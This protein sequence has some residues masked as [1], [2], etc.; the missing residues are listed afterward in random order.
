[1]IHATTEHARRRRLP[2]HF[3]SLE[4]PIGLRGLVAAAPQ[5]HSLMSS[6]RSRGP[7][8]NKCSPLSTSVMHIVNSSTMFN[9]PGLSPAAPAKATL[10]SCIWGASLTPSPLWSIEEG[11]MIA[12][13]GLE[14]SACLA[15]PA[16]TAHG[17]ASGATT[18]RCRLPR[19]VSS[20]RRNRNAGQPGSTNIA[21][22]LRRDRRSP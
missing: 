2:K 9:Q 16:Q 3:H 4:P 11:V 19:P 17:M 1:M 7:P 10:P 20:A 15:Q 22:S 12:S 13:P 21:R 6:R 18:L 14:L 8:H 5:K